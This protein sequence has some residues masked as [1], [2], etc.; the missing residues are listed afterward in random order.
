[1]SLLSLTLKISKTTTKPTL[2]YLYKAGHRMVLNE[3]S[4]HFKSNNDNWQ[5]DDQNY[6]AIAFEHSN[7]TPLAGVRVETSYPHK[8]TPHIKTFKSQQWNSIIH[9]YP[10]KN[11][12]KHKEI[13][14]LWQRKHHDI[15][16]ISLFMPKLALPIAT[17]QAACQFTLIFNAK[18]TFNI[19]ISLDFS[20]N[21]RSEI[22]YPNLYHKAYLWNH[23]NYKRLRDKIHPK[24]TH[25]T[26]LLN[27]HTLA[28]IQYEI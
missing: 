17:G 5:F 14:A 1:M 16:G 8:E 3:R 12:L 24:D 26:E 25:Y 20:I 4:F 15:S 23:K 10:S 22:N 28:H 11:S 7:I 2:S 6:I 21:P 19:P 9:L 13:C 18:Y 27:K